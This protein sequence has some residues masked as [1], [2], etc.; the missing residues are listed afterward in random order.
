MAHFDSNTLN[1]RAK[2]LLKLLVEKYIKEG[3][4]V[5]SR[6]LSKD[7]NVDLSPATIRNVMADLEALGLL[8][9]PHSSAGRI[10]TVQGY[11]LFIDS[12]LS[13]Q[14]LDNGL[15]RDIEQHFYT[16]KI[17]TVS[18]TDNQQLLTIASDLLST[19]TQMAGLVMLPRRDIV[20]LSH[21]ELLTLSENR[22]LAI[23]VMDNDEVQNRIVHLKHKISDTNLQI[24]NNYLNMA[25]T[26]KS[27][28]Q[29]RKNLLHEMQ[30]T[31][32][33]VNQL[34]RDAIDIASQWFSGEKAC[35]DDYLLMGET[36]LMAYKEMDNMSQLRRLFEAFHEKQQIL[37]V[38]DHIIDA[39]GVKILIGEESQS[40]VLEHCSLVAA[41][42]KIDGKTLG[43]LGVIGPTRMAYDRI[44]P[45][46][47]VTAKILG[48]AL[49]P[50]FSVST[51][52][53]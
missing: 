1:G 30:E 19:V 14:P 49:D 39:K 26:G 36:N 47:E 42:Y 22:I 33:E 28:S 29:V 31:K 15:L 45:V 50:K 51:T 21:I 32:Q 4:P 3:L 9:S 2:F 12:L 17:T 11:R 37:H 20:A 53:P 6:T 24:M 16:S 7:S 23:L 18:H 34:M 25:L 35:I 46:V 44:I 10:P 13:V 8:H 52:R 48:A 41:P 40:D 27:L 5:G 43:V 38:L